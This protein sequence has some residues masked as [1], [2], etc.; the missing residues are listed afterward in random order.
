MLARGQLDIPT[1]LLGSVIAVV[2]HDEFAVDGEHGTIIAP[3]KERV[4][5]VLR[6]L[7]VPAKAK[8]KV[9]VALAMG[10]IE[11]LHGASG[12]WGERAEIGVRGEVLF[13]ILIFEA[14]DETAFAGVVQT[15]RLRTQEINGNRG[16]F[17]A[18]KV[19]RRHS[20]GWPHLEWINQEF[21]KLINGG[22][23]RKIAQR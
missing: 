21:R 5:P 11:S 7:D 15:G 10:E 6:N 2:V 3:R 1:L 4:A 20:T 17:A 13:V 23:S 18:S 8:T 22:F 14:A 12:F 19:Q 9:V 16:C